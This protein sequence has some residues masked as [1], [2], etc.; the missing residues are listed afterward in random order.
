MTFFEAENEWVYVAG[1]NE[2]N[3]ICNLLDCAWRLLWL[4][5]NENMKLVRGDVILVLF[6]S[7]CDVA[8]QTLDAA[9]YHLGVSCTNTS[10]PSPVRPLSS[11]F[12]VIPVTIPTINCTEPYSQAGHS[13]TSTLRRKMNTP[14][15]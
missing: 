7:R 9:Q 10:L 1:T 6:L 5:K 12:V 15:V 3:S 14:V 8:Y 11:Q 13:E 4:W 2:M